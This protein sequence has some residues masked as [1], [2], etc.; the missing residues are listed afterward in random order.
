MTTPTTNARFITFE[1]GEGAGKTTQIKLLGA[2]LALAGI[3]HVSTREP[4]GTHGAE[5]IRN[6]VVSGDKERWDPIS[7]TLLMM[8]ARH[9]H[10]RRFI[11]PSLESGRWVLCDRF[12][13]STV[14]YQGYCG[15]VAIEHLEALYTF[16]IGKLRPELT[17]IFDIPPEV[18]LDRAYS[19]DR[20]RLAALPQTENRFERMD[21]DFHKGLR[22]AFLKIAHSDPQRC[23]VVNAHQNE[24]EVH[25]AVVAAVS[26]RLGIVL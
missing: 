26:Q 18:G 10:V 6:L 2:R 17:L 20:H 13:D 15:G 11:G 19:R 12:Q 22:Q 3:P 16:A 14:A 21:A 7:E 8:A 1:G 5:A 25:R 24:S 9:D 4:G 23:V